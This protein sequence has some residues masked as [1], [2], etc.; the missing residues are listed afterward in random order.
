L[1]K[2]TDAVVLEFDEYF[3]PKDGAEA[4]ARVINSMK[5][6]RKI[7]IECRKTDLYGHKNLLDDKGLKIFGE[8]LKRLDSLQSVSLRFYDCFNITEQGLKNLGKGLK[9]LSSLQSIQIDFDYKIR[10]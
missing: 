2:R 8:C 1:K 4:F 5:K 3:K 9:R 6:V 10:V 7:F